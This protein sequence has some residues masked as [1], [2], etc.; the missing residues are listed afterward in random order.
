[1]ANPGKKT[2][3]VT[4]QLNTKIRILKELH[5]T[6]TA[7]DIIELLL[8][9]HLAG[10][11][12]DRLMIEASQTPI[13]QVPK[14]MYATT[15]QRSTMRI[16]KVAFKKDARDPTHN[17]PISLLGNERGQEY[18]LLRENTYQ[19]TTCTS[20]NGTGMVRGEWCFSCNGTGGIR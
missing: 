5:H 18:E 8:T 14:P 17:G 10:H 12:R 19:E 20:C 3:D 4:D 2:I 15:R 16:S 13:E 1:M 6:K 7:A 9:E 11:P